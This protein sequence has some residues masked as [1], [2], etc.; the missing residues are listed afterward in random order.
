MNWNICEPSQH[1]VVQQYYAGS[2]NVMNTWLGTGTECWSST[3]KGL[4]SAV[5]LH[6]TWARADWVATGCKPAMVQKLRKFHK[7][8]L[9]I[10][11]YSSQCLMHDLISH[12][13]ISN[14]AFNMPPVHICYICMTHYAYTLCID[15]WQMLEQVWGLTEIGSIWRSGAKTATFS[16]IV[17][18]PWKFTCSQRL[19]SCPLHTL[20][21]QVWLYT[22]FSECSALHW[23]SSA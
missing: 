15:H 9:K 3:S 12:D 7:H 14:K 10:G 21:W 17:S 22:D 23:M 19:L 18:G 2:S 6:G 11:Q 5:C 13:T 8:Q 16:S 4:V 1:A 20:S